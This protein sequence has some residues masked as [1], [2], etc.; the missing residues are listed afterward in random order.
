[1]RMLKTSDESR[2]WSGVT[3]APKKKKKREDMLITSILAL[4]CFI[5]PTQTTT[6]MTTITTKTKKRKFTCWNSSVI[7]SV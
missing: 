6:T 1:M 7:R 3:T 5:I 4:P 2:G